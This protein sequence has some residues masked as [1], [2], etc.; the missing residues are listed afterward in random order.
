MTT[1]LRESIIVR[2]DETLKLLI[3]EGIREGIQ[4]WTQELGLTTDH[5]AHLRR[6]YERSKLTGNV[7]RRTVLGAILTA[8]L[9]FGYNAMTDHIAKVI[10]QHIDQRST[11]RGVVPPKE[12]PKE[13]G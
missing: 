6:E 13:D 2:D 3:R 10:S 7:V 8:A 9:L 5:W 12:L 1:V 11:V 4:A